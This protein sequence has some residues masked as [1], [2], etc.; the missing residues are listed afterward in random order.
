MALKR[1]LADR[2][3][4]DPAPDDAMAMRRLRALSL[5]LRGHGCPPGLGEPVDVSRIAVNR[6]RRDPFEDSS[7]LRVVNPPNPSPN[8]GTR[9][10]PGRPMVDVSRGGSR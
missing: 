4:A 9:F 1:R 7:R 2:L 6:P 3:Y 8:Q 10:A 5:E